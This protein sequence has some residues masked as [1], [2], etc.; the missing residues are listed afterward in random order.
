[1][2]STCLQAFNQYPGTGIFFQ[3][4]WSVSCIYMIKILVVYTF[5]YLLLPLWEN[6]RRDYRLLFFMPVGRSL[7]NDADQD[8]SPSLLSGR[9][10][11]G[12]SL[13]ILPWIQVV[14]RFFYSMLDLLQITGVAVAI[15]L[16]MLRIKITE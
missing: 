14:A 12:W 6:S 4:L 13:L 15:K 1:M 7:R 9:I 16:F 11:P 3:I 10:Y 2:N 5:L 8:E